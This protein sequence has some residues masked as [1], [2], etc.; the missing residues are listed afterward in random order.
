MSSD[1]PVTPYKGTKAIVISTVSWLGGKNPFLGWAYVASAGVFA[2]LAIA[3]TARHLLKPRHVPVFVHRF[4]MS[5]TL[6]P[7]NWEICRCCHGTGKHD[8]V[9]VLCEYAT[10]L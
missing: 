8:I 6:N 3:G 7:G 1:F 2:L 4:V 5:L 10:V 9:V